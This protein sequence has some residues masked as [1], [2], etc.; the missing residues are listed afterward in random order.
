[1][2]DRETR[3]RIRSY[4]IRAGRMT[5]MQ[6]RAIEEHWQ[7]WGLA[8]EDGVLA[9]DAAFARAGPCVLEIGFGMGLSLLDMAAAAPNTNYIGVEVH[10]PGV[11]KLLHSMNERGVDNIR[12]YRH[13]A[14]EVL[15]DC[16]PDDSLDGVQIFFP[17]PWHKKKHQKRRLIQ[18]PF[19]ALLKRKLRPGGTI[20]LATD[21]E[22]YAQQMMDVLTS[23]QGFSNTCG[24]GQFSPRPAD[25]PLTKFE[26]RGERLG[27]GVWDLIFS[28]TQ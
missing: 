13:D 25:R 8:Y 6:K 1:M 12:I 28:R 2:T 17:D 15:R 26:M 21:W 3:Q 5:E 23:A 10:K 27:H 16:I 4:V 14:V 19:V 18:P 9:I 7:R 20:H 24:E 22:H 11:G